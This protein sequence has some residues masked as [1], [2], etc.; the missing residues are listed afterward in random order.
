MNIDSKKM[1]LK[2]TYMF[3]GRLSSFYIQTHN[4]THTAYYKN[5]NIYFWVLY[6]LVM[7]KELHI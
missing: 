6:Y 2:I 4:I 3:I 5:D 1:L 7:T